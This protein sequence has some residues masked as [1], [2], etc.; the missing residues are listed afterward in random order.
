[1]NDLNRLELKKGA[2]YEGLDCQTRRIRLARLEKLPNQD[3]ELVTQLRMTL[4]AA[5]RL[6]RPIHVFRGAPSRHPAIFY[7][8]ALPAWLGRLLGGDS[9][10]IEQLPEALAK[11]ELFE[12]FADKNGLG[13]GWAKQL[14]DPE[15]TVVLG[16]LC[17]AWAL[18]VDQ[19]GSGDRKKH[20]RSLIETRTR[21]R[22][23]ALI[24]NT[25]GEPVNLEDNHD[26]LIRLAWL[27]TR[28]QK[29]VGTGASAN[30]QLLCWK[31]AL[32][33]YPGAERSSSTDRTALILGLAGT[34][35]E[36]L[37]R[38]S[39]A[40]AKK[41]RDDRPLDEACI[42]F[43]RHFAHEV[44]ENVFKSKEPTNREQRRAAAIYRFAL[45]EAYRERSIAESMPD[46][47]L[48][49]E[50]DERSRR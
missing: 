20:A 21:E 25:G 9:L 33:F 6:G 26:P 36:E 11:L 27:A 19:R 48:A 13:I 37:T 42:D 40:A 44:W 12:N 35:E 24:R 49:A 10:R 29:Q 5:R 2:V 38:K 23:L 34:L 17:V 4:T 31:T 41:H 47:S 1:M 15:P 14:A 39:D 30:K 7:S 43:A 22:A 32:A 50:A 16:A 8:D 28:I 18:A 3:A 46:D 45:L